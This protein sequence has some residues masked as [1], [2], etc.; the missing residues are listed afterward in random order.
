MSVVGKTLDIYKVDILKKKEFESINVKDHV[1]TS[2]YTKDLG[3][4]PPM[5]NHC[6]N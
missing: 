4:I 2:E 3:I 5:L 6:L 1:S